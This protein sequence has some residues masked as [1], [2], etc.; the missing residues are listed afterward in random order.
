MVRRGLLALLLPGCSLFVKFDD[1]DIPIDAAP[2]AFAPIA[3][4][5]C[6]FGEPNDSPDTAFA[7]MPGSTGPAAICPNGDGTVTDVDYYKLTVPD[8]TASITI[9]IDF[10]TFDRGDL[11]ILMFDSTGATMLAQSRGV[12]SSESITCPGTS[13][14]CTA[15]GSGDYLLEV[16]PGLAGDY[17][18]YNLTYAVTPSM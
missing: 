9:G 6:M 18:Q 3:A 17:N 1:K 8:M 5:L 16:I 10:T 4:D 7:I 15:L 11:D 13:P 12:G 2:D 14:P